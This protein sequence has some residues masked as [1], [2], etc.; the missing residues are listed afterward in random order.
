MAAAC[1]C[2]TSLCCGFPMCKAVGLPGWCRAVPASPGTQ[3]GG[4]L[5]GVQGMGSHREEKHLGAAAAD[6]LLL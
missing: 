4:D 1:L 2:V 6:F 5:V 3:G